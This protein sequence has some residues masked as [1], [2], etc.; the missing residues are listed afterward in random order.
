MYQITVNNETVFAID[1]NELD[2]LDS[3]KSKENH[4][5]ILH[6]NISVNAQILNH[7]FRKKTYTVKVNNNVYDVEIKNELDLLITELGFSIGGTKQVNQIHAP[8]PGLIL[9][10]HVKEGQEVKE[11]D[12]LLI[13]E[14]MKMENVIKSPRDG[15]IKSIKVKTIR[16]L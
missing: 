16:I 10:I 3:I 4:Y 13:F 6:N 1:S 15:I 11:D 14:A 8:M 12:S 9:E 2:N 7:N 5:H